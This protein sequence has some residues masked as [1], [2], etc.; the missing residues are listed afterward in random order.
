MVTQQY[1]RPR[2]RASS[3]NR[4]LQVIPPLGGERGPAG[5]QRRSAQLQEAAS[6]PCVTLPMQNIK[7]QAYVTPGNEIPAPV[8]LFGLSMD[9]KDD[10]I[11]LMAVSHEQG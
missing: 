5:D 10:G 9:S 6:V 1:G 4:R 8:P 3:I 2:A 11:A 7:S